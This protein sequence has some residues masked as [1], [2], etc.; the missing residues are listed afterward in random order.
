VFD[1]SSQH[2]LKNGKIKSNAAPI[3]SNA[4]T[5]SCQIRKPK[6]DM[7]A[8]MAKQCFNDLL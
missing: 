5:A 1:T 7:A 4:T 8:I 6:I 2:H 3:E